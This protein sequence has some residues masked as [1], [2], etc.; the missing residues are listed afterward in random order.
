MKLIAREIFF[1]AGD[2]GSGFFLLSEGEWR[3]AGLVSSALDQDCAVNKFV[4]FTNVAKFTEWIDR[5]IKT[6]D[7]NNSF[8]SIFNE[9]D[10]EEQQQPQESNENLVN[11]DCKF[12]SVG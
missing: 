10:E 6:T 3:I 9:F 12:E 5:E 11:V 1:Y 2:S 4:L 8:D 7:S